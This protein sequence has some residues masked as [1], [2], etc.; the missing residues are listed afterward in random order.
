[1]LCSRDP[2]DRPTRV[3]I[4][5]VSGVGKSALARRIS[6]ALSLPYTEIDGL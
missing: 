2:L 5:G 4:A 6:D 1:M 3:V